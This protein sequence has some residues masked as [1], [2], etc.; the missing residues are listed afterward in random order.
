MEFENK[1]PTLTVP[2]E[3]SQKEFWI[4]AYL[5]AL[6]RTNFEGAVN[7]ADNALKA[8]NA[9]WSKMMPQES[10]QYAHHYPIGVI[11]NNNI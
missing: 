4:R 9:R 5:A 11:T 8:C 3:M 10:W 1:L 7:E 2:G 6:H